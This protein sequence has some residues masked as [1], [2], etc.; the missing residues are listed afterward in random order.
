MSFAT[1]SGAQAAVGSRIDVRGNKRVDA[2][3]IRGA[4]AIKPG[5]SFTNT[6]IDAAVKSLFN[7]GLFSDVRISQSGR[8]LVVSVTEFS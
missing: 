1:V 7:M 4:I 6:D 3:T 2:A 5:K 8:A